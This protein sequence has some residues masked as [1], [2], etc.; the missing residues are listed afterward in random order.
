M[1][2]G[3]EQMAEMLLP[4]SSLYDC[5]R[6]RKLRWVLNHLPPGLEVTL[7]KDFSRLTSL[8]ELE[9]SLQGD[10]VPDAASDRE[11][12]GFS[13]PPLRA[14]SSL[15]RVY[16]NGAFIRGG[17]EHLP[18]RCLLRR[19]P[20]RGRTREEIEPTLTFGELALQG[21]LNMQTLN[22]G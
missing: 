3:I 8:E 22:L 2:T 13:L 18:P 21:R 6:L 11:G 9:I 5:G 1:R 17:R 20:K 15:R 14:L 16:L 19:G 12:R 7:P 4:G 10:Q